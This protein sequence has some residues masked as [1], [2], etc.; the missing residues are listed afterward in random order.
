MSAVRA[1]KSTA[2]RDLMSRRVATARPETSL[3]ATA[4]LMKARKI[5]HLP[6]VDNGGRL[7]GIVTARDL[8]QAL[9][10]PAIQDR[11]EELV[12]LLDTLA[13]RD[14]MTRGVVSVRAATSI[15]DAARLMHERKLGALPV[16]ERDRLV[17]ILTETD[18]LGAFQRL[19]GATT[20]SA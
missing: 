7:V 19:L 6:V 10:A 5:R 20:S 13:V 3:G 18:V 15:R 9:F 8:R 1:T 4:K 2:V 12:G 11:P 16:V 14:V 17:G